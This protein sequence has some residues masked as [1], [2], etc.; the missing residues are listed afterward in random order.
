MYEKDGEKY[1]VV[2]T[3]MHY[4]NAAPDNWVEGAE[5]Y[6]KGWIECFYG[7]H[8]LGPEN[9]RWSLE[10]YQRYTE[11]DLMKDVFDQ[12]HVDVAIFQPTDLTEWYKEGFNT[13]ERDATLFEKY[14]GK[15]V[16]N[17]R[18]DPR[19]GE[20]GLKTLR[21]NVERW[22]CKGVKLYTAEWQGD[23]RGYKLDDPWSRRYLEECL[24]LGIT[25]IHVHK[26]PTIRPL[27]RDAFDVADID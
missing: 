9:T 25:N 14:P 18:W 13:T 24:A 19:E 15:F 3:H 16:L 27:D 11:E 20:D 2:D 26:G 6:A 23:S 5:Q 17:T 8:G 21:H 7:Y 10:K 12:G 1:F 22:G 4:W